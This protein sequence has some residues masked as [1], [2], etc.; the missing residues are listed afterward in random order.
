MSIVDGDPDPVVPVVGTP[1]GVD[2]GSPAGGG[3]GSLA[4][5]GSGSLPALVAQAASSDDPGRKQRARQLAAIV[6]TLTVS[7]KQAGFRAVTAGR[8]LADTVVDVAPHIAVRDRS[9]LRRQYQGLTD[10]E[11][12]DKLISTAAKTTAAVGAAAGSLAAIEFAAPPALLAAPV[13]LAAETLAS[14]AVE[15]KLVAELHEIAGL[16]V[17][18]GLARSAGPYLA[19]W[20]NRRAAKPGDSVGI[21]GVATAAAFRELRSRLLRRMGRSAT[22]MAPFLAGA[23]A[24]AEVNRRATRDLGEKIQAELRGMHDQRADVVL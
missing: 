13:Q 14:V 4:G 6:P 2:D 12:S 11:I 19:A 3:G 17:P 18:G 20:V 10:D 1:Q 23:V 8:W 24:G 7:A 22:S 21:G 9:T 16:A 5:G 15:L